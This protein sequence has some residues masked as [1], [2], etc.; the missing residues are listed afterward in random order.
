MLF[1]SIHAYADEQHKAVYALVR[2][3][4][5]KDPRLYVITKDFEQ[6]RKA[7]AAAQTS[8]AKGLPVAGRQLRAGLQDQGA[9]VFYQLPPAGVP[10]KG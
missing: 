5:E 6:A 10:S 9:F 2:A 4:G 7:F 8:V 3:K 1:R